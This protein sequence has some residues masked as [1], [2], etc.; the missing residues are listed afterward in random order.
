MEATTVGVKFGR[1]ID[2][3]HSWSLRI[4]QYV[5]T[6]DESPAEAFGQLAQQNLYPD[7]EASIVQFNYS[8]IW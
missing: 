4:E 8:F 1:E 5:Q 6:G 7:V 3:Q 2:D